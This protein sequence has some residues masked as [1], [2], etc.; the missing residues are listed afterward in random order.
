MK[1]SSRRS[2]L[3]HAA[4]A[5]SLVAAPYIVPASAF[6]ANERITMGCIGVGNQGINNLRAFLYDNR[7][8]VT[9]LC[10]VNDESI[11]YWNNAKAGRL[12]GEA[13][14]KDQYGDNFKGVDLYID[15][16][17][18]L[19]QDDI[20]SVM[21]AVPDHWH[22][23]LYTDAAKAGK[24]IYG[25]KPLSLTVREGR[26]MSDTVRAEGVRFQTGS[27]Q[28]SDRNFRHAAEL[29]QNGYIGELKRVKCG[30]PGGTPDISKQGH[31]TEPEPVPEGFDYETWL[32]PAPD[33]PY[34]PARS[35]V[36][37]RW[38]FD[39]SGG[40]LT[41]W[42]GHHP[43]C[44]QWGMGTDETGPVEV[45]NPRA[46]YST[47]PVFNTAVEYS[48]DCMYE[49]GVVLNVSNRNRGGVVFEGTE[50]KIWVDRGKLETKPG[51]LVDVKIKDDEIHL[52]KSDNHHQN[53][54]DCVLSGE[55]TAAPIEKA[56]RSVSIAHIGNIAMKLDRD[57]KWNP[58]KE[59]FVGDDE[60]NEFL[61]RP[62]RGPWKLGGLPEGGR[63]LA[64]V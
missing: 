52:Y 21:I 42:S 45:R 49:N 3:K 40:Q 16:R 29:V 46:I 24:H 48:F 44:A 63:S 22:A 55:E 57:L 53:F 8:Q 27:Q 43:D 19:E 1:L 50:G 23:L 11:G 4:G 26:I 2:F 12:V 33:A 20:D 9:A 37:W 6:G 5:A 39:Y 28:R 41:D 58:D 15:Y 30:L 14:V 59:V 31:R 18:L 17:E 7:V 13:I 10:D 38:V 64:D 34:I 60:A 35:H 32:G 36:N 61:H 54:I 47:D 62:Y 25:E 56:H 51:K